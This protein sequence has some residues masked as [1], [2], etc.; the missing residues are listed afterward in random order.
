MTSSEPKILIISTRVDLSTD[1]VIEKLSKFG[2]GFIRI[3]TEDFPITAES[4]FRINHDAANPA[5]L[6]SS[7]SQQS[8]ALNEIRSVWYRRHRLPQLPESVVKAHAEYSLRESEWFLRGCIYAA[9]SSS[10][11]SWMSHPTC[12]Q[13]A[14]SKIYQLT[15]AKSIGL[16]V[17]ST[18]ISNSPN[19]IRRLFE[20]NNGRIIAKPLRLGYFDYGERQ[21]SVYTN[22]VQWDHLLND[23]SLKLAPVIFQELVTKRFDIRVTIVGELVFAAAI[24]SQDIESA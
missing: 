13:T 21:T 14:E 22:E 8:F 12:L 15:Q 5:W 20:T 24:H 19:T 23:S 16:R 7:E 17:P 4:S 9:A 6:W 3:N 1:Y 18:L 10:N 2:A 11:I